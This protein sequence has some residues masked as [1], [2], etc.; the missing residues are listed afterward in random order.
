MHFHIVLYKEAHARGMGLQPPPSPQPFL[1]SKFLPFTH[2][3]V[4]LAQATPP[5]APISKLSK[6]LLLTKKNVTQLWSLLILSSSEPWQSSL[7]KLTPFQNAFNINPFPE[8]FYLSLT[9]FQ[10]PSHVPGYK[11]HYKK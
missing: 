5:L 8:G 10:K 2:N 11:S 4:T 1:A 3:K 9:F 7:F 6:T